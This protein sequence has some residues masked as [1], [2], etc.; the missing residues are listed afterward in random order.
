MHGRILDTVCTSCGDTRHNATSPICEALA[1]T[2]KIMELQKNDAEP[3]VPIEQLPACEKCQ[4][5]LRPGVVWFG[6]MPQHLEK[7]DEL[8]GEADL[9]IVVGTSSTVSIQ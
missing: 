2:E 3:V 1:G 8:V 6:E 5:I 9:A 4:A 7:I